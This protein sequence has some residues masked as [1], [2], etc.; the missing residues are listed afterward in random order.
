MTG[1]LFQP[2]VEPLESF[3]GR[4]VTVMG[5]GLFGG[6]RG[7]AEFLCQQGAEV[8]VTDL[9]TEDI[10]APV[11]DTLRHLPIEWVLGQHREED[12]LG[13]DLVVPSPAVPR[14]AP[15]LARCRQRGIAL[16]TEMNLFFKYCR[17]KICSVTG[18]NGKTTTTSLIGDIVRAHSPGTRVGGNIGKSLLPEVTSIGPDQWVILELSSFQLE[19]LVGLERRPQVSVV[20]NLSPNHL[21]RHGTYADYV[22]AKR[23]IIEPGGEPNVAVLNAED[24]RVR[25]WQAPT[26]RT[27]FFGRTG[28]VLPRAPGVWVNLDTSDVVVVQ[29]EQ[30]T[31]VRLFRTDD[32]ALPGRFNLLNAAAAAAA[33]VAMGV[34]AATIRAAIRSFRTVEHRL[35]RFHVADGVEYF[36][37]SI[38]TNPE[39]TIAALEALGPRIVLVCGGAPG[40]RRSYRALGQAIARRTRCVIL[41]GE[42]AADIAAAIPSRR[43]GPLIHV[44]G[45]FEEAVVSTRR[46]AQ[47]GDQVVLSPGCSSYDMFV[48]FEERGRSFKR[49]VRREE[50]GGRARG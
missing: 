2:E 41:I 29:R 45:G 34:P 17:G 9:R 43:D 23:T 36:N 48:N 21:D 11:I 4:K 14:D 40:G 50:P 33:S 37:D 1:P 3:R 22:D 46:F 24:A 35:E 6:G 26:R 25:T 38:A 39:S 31:P 10:L 44:A 47:T 27:L 15:L 49:L 42:T 20:T 13:A 7:A 8:I 18:T 19:D 5:L 32:L 12:F 30:Q 16:D 28:R